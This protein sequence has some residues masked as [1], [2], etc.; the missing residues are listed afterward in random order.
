MASASHED[1][2]NKRRK[3][4]SSQ[5]GEEGHILTADAAVC[6]Q[7]KNLAKHV[8]QYEQEKKEGREGK[9]PAT[10]AETKREKADQP[11]LDD[12]DDDVLS[13]QDG[14][15]CA[16]ASRRSFNAGIGEVHGGHPLRLPP[17][18]GAGPSDPITVHDDVKTAL[19]CAEMRADTLA[20]AIAAMFID[21][22]LE[23]LASLT[24]KKRITSSDEVHVKLIQLGDDP[25][26]TSKIVN[27][28]PTFQ[29]STCITLSSQI[30]CNVE[31]Y[32]D[33]LV[34]KMHNRETLPLDLA[35]TFDSLRTMRMKLNPKKCI[36]RDPA[37]NLLG[38]LVFKAIQGIHPLG[39]IGTCRPFVWTEEAERSL[40]NLK[41]YLSSPKAGEPLL[42]YIAD[43]PSPRRGHE[44]PKRLGGLMATDPVGACPRSTQA[45]TALTPPLR[46]SNPGQRR[47]KEALGPNDGLGPPQN[48]RGTSPPCSVA[49]NAP[50][51]QRGHE[52]PE[53]LGSPMAPDPVETC[54]SNP[55][56]DTPEPN[57][58]NAL[59]RALPKGRHQSTSSMRP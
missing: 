34:V 52:A 10:P 32:V 35:K 53:R 13:F 58:P 4:K 8:R 47:R 59:A 16:H 51:P 57:A 25:S 24:P 23:A 30:G 19:A 42:L 7:F 49:S 29:R 6:P 14:G 12:N 37:S 44:A 17:A 55:K 3:K 39:S 2:R 38:F 43:A 20:V 41:Q 9:A 15:A 31:A 56:P 28:G 33:D 21:Q 36:F 26:K 18:Q 1:R 45:T 5:G 27:A 46:K 11:A 50:S 48:L 40:S 22:D 54:P